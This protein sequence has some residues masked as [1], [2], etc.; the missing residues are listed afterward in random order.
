MIHPWHTI[1]ASWL[2]SSHTCVNSVHV[3]ICATQWKVDVWKARVIK[4]EQQPVYSEFTQGSAQHFMNFSKHV[5]TLPFFCNLSFH[6]WFYLTT[7]FG[8]DVFWISFP[9]GVSYASILSPSTVSQ[10]AAHTPLINTLLCMPCSTKT[11]WYV[12][13]CHYYFLLYLISLIFSLLYFTF[14]WL[15]FS[16]RILCTLS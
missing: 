12:C 10:H 2:P 15:P 7:V 14:R 13:Y 6:A 9:V 4:Q 11:L 8:W 3:L 1:K 5:A 16:W